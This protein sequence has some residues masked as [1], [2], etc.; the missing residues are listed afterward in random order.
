MRAAVALR[1]GRTT[2]RASAWFMGDLQYMY[3]RMPPDPPAP[4]PRPSIA[5]MHPY[6]WEP[7]SAEI[8]RQVGVPED[9]VVRFDTNTS[10]WP[11]ASIDPTGP[12]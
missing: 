5:R 3:V 7:P 12:F 2:K 10:P 11:G 4:Q 9:Q 8:A 6:E 1:S